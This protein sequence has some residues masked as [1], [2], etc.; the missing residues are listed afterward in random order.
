MAVVVSNRADVCPIF[1]TL[2]FPSQ[3][4]GRKTDGLQ[5]SELDEQALE[6]LIKHGLNERVPDAY[7]RFLQD[8]EQFHDSMYA[9]ERAEL[10]DLREKLQTLYPR[11][12][13]GVKFE[14][15]K[16]FLAVFTFVFVSGDF[17]L[18]LITL[19]LEPLSLTT[20]SKR[21]APKT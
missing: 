14:R 16:A 18:S 19:A 15:A 13:L 3:R 12:L 1:L 10:K 2:L 17:S 6:I 7:S 8:R 11:L 4:F 5:F 20:S 9:H 21:Q